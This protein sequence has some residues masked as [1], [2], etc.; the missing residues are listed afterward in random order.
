MIPFLPNPTHSTK[1]SILPSILLLFFL[2]LL[3]G[4]TI[5]SCATSPKAPSPSAIQAKNIEQEL[6]ALTQLYEKKDNQFF[7]HLHSLFKWPAFFKESVQHDFETF[8]EIK[9]RLKMTRLD[10]TKENLKAGIY[11]EGSWETSSVLPLQ[12]SG[13]ALFIFSADSPPRLL[14]IRGESPFGVFQKNGTPATKE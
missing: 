5:I 4:G 12:Q 13:Q 14:E 9:M 10:I 8:S 7:A 2:A 1:V 3:A 6:S 11:W